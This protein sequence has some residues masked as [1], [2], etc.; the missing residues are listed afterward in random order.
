M[1]AGYLDGASGPPLGHISRSGWWLRWR[2]GDKDWAGSY[3]CGGAGL[4]LEAMAFGRVG[5]VIIEPSQP[6]FMR[7]DC[8]VD[9]AP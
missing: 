8:R 5:E 6:H 4:G 2:F 7:V 9:F 3:Y 1:A